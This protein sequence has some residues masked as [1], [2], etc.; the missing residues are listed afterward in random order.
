MRKARE[1]VDLPDDVVLVAR[2]RKHDQEAFSALVSRYERPLE[3]ILM[4]FARDRNQ[5]R[6]LVQEAVLR[7]FQNL[8]RYREDHRFST[9]FFRIGVN[10]AITARRRA[11]CE[12]RATDPSLPGGPA[13]RLTPPESPLEEILRRED[14][15]GLRRAMDTLPERYRTVLRMRYA[16]ELG[17][18]EIAQRLRTTP[19]TISIVLFRAKQR[20]R[21]ILD[22]DGDAGP[23]AALDGA[24]R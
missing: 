13:S 7:A 8:H 4:A 9:W 12:A 10:L 6:D 5:A 20:L 11:A 18:Q 2:A 16:D 14:L 21:E 24:E 15:E 3:G 19:N 1:P 22:P 17:C 23:E